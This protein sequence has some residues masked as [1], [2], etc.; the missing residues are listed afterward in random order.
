L[1]AKYYA[2]ESWQNATFQPKNAHFVQFPSQTPHVLRHF[3]LKNGS[4][5]LPAGSRSSLFSLRVSGGKYYAKPIHPIR[6]SL[7]TKKW[8]FIRLTPQLLLQPATW[9][10]EPQTW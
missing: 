8:P 2:K 10:L 7:L 9:N 6:S 4:F 5:S 3:G 1:Y